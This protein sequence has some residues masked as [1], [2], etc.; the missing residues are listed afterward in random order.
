MKKY[1]FILFLFISSVI[2]AQIV[3]IPDPNFKSALIS[4]G[5]DTNNDGEIQVSEAEARIELNVSYANIFSLEGI[6]S[7][8]NL[9]NLRC[10]N[11]ELTS[12]NVSQNGNL[13]SLYCNN[14]QLTSLY[15]PQNSNLKLL[16][17][18]N[19]Q[20]TDL[21]IST[22]S[23]L[24]Y[25][26]CSGN[27]LSSLDLTQNSNLEQLYCSGNQLMSLDISQN[28]LLK[29]IHCAENQ[30]SVLNVEQN[31]LLERIYC[32][33]NQLTSLD[34]SQNS[35]ILELFCMSNELTELNLSNG[36]T[37]N[38]FSMIANNNP[39]LICIQVDDETTSFPQCEINFGWCK[40]PI[41]SY[42]ENCTFG[43]E[44]FNQLSITLHPNPT[45]GLLNIES[46]EPIEVIKIYTLNG[47][48]IK[49]TTNSLV[50]VSELK[51]GLYIVVISNK[52]KNR[53]VKKLIK[54]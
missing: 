25:L 35:N 16:F 40:D 7:F 30:I 46:N 2:H 42:S 1:Y 52:F 36:N 28:P 31:P 19:N 37:Q 47:L 26:L 23:N 20:L 10:N 39:D 8:I 54:L 48:F 5:V 14:N 24:E 50:N 3:N 18:H 33:F 27:Q 43:I 34:L 9:E 11:N 17:C 6:H 38:I 22:N 41:A 49:E 51:S 15:L 53:V 44:D 21:E 32:S 13:E 45:R 12:I 4:E 29:L